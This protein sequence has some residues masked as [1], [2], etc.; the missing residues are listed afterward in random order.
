MYLMWQENNAKLIRCL[1]S[2]EC[3][4][5][6]QYSLENIISLLIRKYSILIVYLI[7]IY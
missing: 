4:N 2:L 7:V 3:E 1:K 5:I 6:Y